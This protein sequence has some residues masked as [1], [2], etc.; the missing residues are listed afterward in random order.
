MEYFEE[1]CSSEVIEVM[2]ECCDVCSQTS[3]KEV[4]ESQKEM[5]AIVQTVK[6]LPSVGEKQGWQTI[7]KI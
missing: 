5:S 4:V 2:D 3:D 1:P 6:E 7:I